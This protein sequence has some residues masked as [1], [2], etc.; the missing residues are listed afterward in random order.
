MPRRSPDPSTPS[1][2]TESGTN[3]LFAILKHEG[4]PGWTRPDLGDLINQLG[5][6]SKSVATE[7]IAAGFRRKLAEQST[8]ERGGDRVKKS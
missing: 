6:A 8:W 4:N 3:K 5:T 1:L 2:S 7:E